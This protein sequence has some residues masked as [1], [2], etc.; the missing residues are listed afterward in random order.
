MFIHSVIF[1]HN[2]DNLFFVRYY[3]NSKKNLRATMIT[4]ITK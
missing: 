1:L 2:L 3:I 4:M